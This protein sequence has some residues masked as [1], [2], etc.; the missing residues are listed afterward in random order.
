MRESTESSDKV[1]EAV[2]VFLGLMAPMMTLP[3]AAL[4]SKVEILSTRMSPLIF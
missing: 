1:R 4:I 2:P 3:F